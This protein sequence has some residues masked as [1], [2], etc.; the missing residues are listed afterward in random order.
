MEATVFQ[1][2][3]STNS[4]LNTMGRTVVGTLYVQVYPNIIPMVGSQYANGISKLL[5]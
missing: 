4:T 2:L 3:I 1:C 5:R